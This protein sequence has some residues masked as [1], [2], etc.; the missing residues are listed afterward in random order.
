M[1]IS[2]RI[3]LGLAAGVL[4]TMYYFLL[5]FTIA[6]VMATHWPAW[7]FGAFPTRHIAATAWLA[8]L[9]TFAVL[10]AALPVAIASVVIARR[11]AVLLGVTAGILAT[12]VSIVP[13]LGPTVWPIIWQSHPVFFIT[14]QIKLAVAVPFVAWVILG[15][16]SNNR[17]ERSRDVSSLSQGGGR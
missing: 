4:A 12:V 8:T 17:L 2:A 1:D 16:T 5:I 15:A 13:S 11:R 10:I 14:D 9:H 3:R 7:W 6:W